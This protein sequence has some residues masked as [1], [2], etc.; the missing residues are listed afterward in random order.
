[1]GETGQSKPTQGADGAAVLTSERY[2]SQ[3]FLDQELAHVFGRTWFVIAR[4]S[5]V[6]KAGDGLAVD[7]LGHAWLVVRGADGNIRT[8]VNACGHRGTRL[9]QDRCHGAQIRCPYHAWSYDL[10]GSLASVPGMEGFGAFDRGSAGLRAVRTE[11]W[12]G[13]VWI[14]L[15][16]DASPLRSYLGVVADQL[17]PYRLEEMRPLQQRSFTID[18]NWKAILDQATESYHVRAVHPKSIGR[19]IQTTA[20]FQG[21]GP[22]HLQTIPIADYAWRKHLDRRSAPGDLAVS[23][24]QLRLFHKYVLFPNTLIN[25]MPY[26]LTVFR[27]IPLTPDTCRFHYSFHVRQD[28]GALPRLRGYLTLLASR[29]ILEED[30]AL[31]RPFQLGNRAAGKQRLHLHREEGPLA[32]FHGTI[33]RLIAQGEARR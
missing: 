23:P 30:F 3:A 18:C 22:H 16:R 21:L 12:G 17:E 1:M 9:V 31:L 13:F 4:C 29:Y 20:T 33:D 24:E 8:F 15:D 14:T 32:W 6:D 7:E 2:T 28:A 11:C 19:F 26:H 25:V 27:V 10:D 5:D